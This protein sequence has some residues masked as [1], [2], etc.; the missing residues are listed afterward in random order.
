M[1]S[2][3]YGRK[4]LRLFLR[5]TKQKQN[6]KTTLDNIYKKKNVYVHYS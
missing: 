6:C 1:K 4:K 2:V 3:T 5:Y